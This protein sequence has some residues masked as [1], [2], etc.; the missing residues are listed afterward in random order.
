MKKIIM[1]IS[2]LT[3]ILI[4]APA[5]A[6]PFPTSNIVTICNSSQFATLYGA[7]WLEG[8]AFFVIGGDVAM[9][10]PLNCACN[11]ICTEL[12]SACK[13]ACDESGDLAT[14][15]EVFHCKLACD[16]C[17]ASCNGECDLVPC[18]PNAF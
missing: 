15:I 7:A 9:P 11:D 16:S 6:D 12:Q 8:C 18:N 1:I 17:A 14:D 13:L 4:S 10:D 3:L 5:L 2:L